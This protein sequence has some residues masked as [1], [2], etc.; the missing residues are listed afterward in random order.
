M[1]QAVQ[2]DL[3]QPAIYDVVERIFSAAPNTVPVKRLF[4]HLAGI[5]SDK[6]SSMSST[7]L[8]ALLTIKMAKPAQDSHPDA[9]TLP[10]ASASSSASC[11]G[12]ASS[13]SGPPAPSSRAGCSKCSEFGSDDDLDGPLDALCGALGVQRPD[14]E[15]APTADPEGAMR[16]PVPT[17]DS[18]AS[19]ASQPPAWTTTTGYCS[20]RFRVS[21]LVGVQSLRY[22]LD[23]QSPYWSQRSVDEEAAVGEK[24]RDE[25]A[26]ILA[27][28][29]DR[30]KG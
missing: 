9:A 27:L 11:S 21:P 1:Y 17:T 6:R 20:S 25:M 19:F 13:A 14:G 2:L 26:Q 10:A 22:A 12:S 28:L 7:L 30:V 24:D 29:T 16:V 4:S 18:D 23:C 3:V 8:K 5:L 15:N